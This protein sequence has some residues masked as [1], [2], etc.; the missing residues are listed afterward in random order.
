MMFMNS[1]AAQ[2]FVFFLLDSR[3]RQP[4]WLSV[5]L[6]YHCTSIQGRVRE[7]TD[8]VLKK[9]DCRI[10]N[11]AIQEIEYLDKVVADKSSSPLSKS[12]KFSEKGTYIVNIVLITITVVIS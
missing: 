3:L 7:E 1:L 9:Y 2:A 8:V 12:S 6:S 5:C 10:T 11:E 4:P